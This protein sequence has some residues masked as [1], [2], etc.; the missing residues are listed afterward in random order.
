M[1]NVTAMSF[2]VKLKIA[3]ALHTWYVVQVMRAI[4]QAVG[5]I[6]RKDTTMEPLVFLETDGTSE[7]FIKIAKKIVNRVGQWQ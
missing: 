1:P 6:N 5:R 3:A 2:E 7:E 4:N